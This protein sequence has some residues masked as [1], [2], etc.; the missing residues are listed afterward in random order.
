M[1]DL[2]H[3]RHVLPLP[4]A[5]KGGLGL[6]WEG[7]ESAFGGSDLR[8]KLRV[9]LEDFGGHGLAGG[10]SLVQS[11]LMLHCVVAGEINELVAGHHPVRFSGYGLAF[12][13]RFLGQIPPLI[14]EPVL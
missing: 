1:Q 8:R 14:N 5:I 7:G 9:I 13:S 3:P 6:F 11:E 10:K 12:H 2:F 4:S